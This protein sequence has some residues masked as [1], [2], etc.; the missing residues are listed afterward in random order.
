MAAA[1]VSRD[2]ACGA[3]ELCASRLGTTAAGYF[4]CTLDS[5]IGVA[6]DA[7]VGVEPASSE[8]LYKVL[9]QRQNLN[10]AERRRMYFWL[11]C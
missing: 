9:V 6:A 10:A 7:N 8:A 1:T 11:R 2:A 4:R 5:D 3:T